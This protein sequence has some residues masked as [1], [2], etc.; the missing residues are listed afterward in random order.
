MQEL[1]RGESP[2]WFR[3]VVR[4]VGLCGGVNYEQPYDY[5]NACPT[6][7]AGSEPVGPLVAQLS[8]MGRKLLDQTAHEGHVVTVRGLA[9]AL[10]AAGMTGLEVRPVRRAHVAVP[11]SGY[12]WLRVAFQWPPMAPTSRVVTEDLCPQC[13]RT[14][15]Y[16]LG[17]EP[18][19]WHYSR[20]PDDAADFGYTWERF[21]I[22][23]AKAWTAGRR[24]VGG[25]GGLI[26]SGSA[27]ALL[28]S[29][30]VRHLEYV[31]VVFDEARHPTSRRS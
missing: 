27:R 7:G 20:P 25:A 6:C 26:V 15:Y 21:G 9:D 3:L 2:V 28:E 4:T 17:A 8:R 31:P 23:R 5:A 29:L 10:V 16:D 24:G 12:C 18:G 11:D 22:W 1:T 14:G 13:Q 30:K 19:A